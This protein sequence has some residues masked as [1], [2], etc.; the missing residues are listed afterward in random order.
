MKRSM[1]TAVAVS[2]LLGALWVPGALGQA[3]YGSILGTVTDPSG[4]AVNG[5]KVSATSQS[6][7]VSVQA[8]SNESGN[9]DITH[10]IPDVYTVRVEA[11][12]FKVLE[13][14]DVQ[15]SADAGAR[16][17]GQFQLGG[18]S[19][20]VEVTSE[21]PQLKTDREDVSV[22]FS[23]KQLEEL[24]IFNRNF[25]S[26]ELLTPG[27][28]V[29]TGWSHAATE[30]PQGSKQIFVNGQHFSGTG[31][32][33][34]GTD[35]QDAILGIIIVNPSLDSV[36][37]TKITTQNYDAEFGKALG[38]IMTAQTKSG[39]NQ[40][41]GSGYFYDLD[42][43]SAA[44]N[45]FTGTPAPNNWKQFG[46]AVGGHIIK[47]KLFYFG[48]LEIT[49]R[50]EGVSLVAT[51]PTANVRNTCLSATSANCDL[52][53]YLTAN[54]GG[55]A[56][57][58]YNPYQA[59]GTRT[60]YAGNIIPQAAL[61]AVDANFT[62]GLTTSEAILAL[63]P[64]PNATGI[65]NGTVDNYTASGSGNFNDYQYVAR[66]DY[67][68]TQKLQTFGRFS[69]AHFKLSGP[70]VF[71]TAIGGPGLGPLGLAG[72]SVIEN[73]SLATGFNYTLSTSLLTDFR[74]GFFRYNPHST[75]FDGTVAAAT[76]LGIPGL[77]TSD[78]STGG[79]PA[80]IFDQ[81]IGVN[82]S[83]NN[84]IGEGLGI[85]RCNCPLLEREQGI[86][87]VNNWTKMLGNHQF[88][89]GADLR[90]ANNL[91]IPSDNNRTGVLN[92]NHAGTSDNNTG[93]L[94]IATFL[95][96]EVT[97][98]NRYVGSATEQQSHELQNRYFF[99]GQDTWRV[100][101]KL[102]FNYGLRWEF[103]TP[104]H[105]SGQGDGGFAILPEGVIRVAGYGGIGLNGNTR[106]NFNQF[107]PRLGIAYEVSPKTVIRMGYGRSYDI[108]VFGSLFG[109]T[110]TQ[111]LP[112]LANQ[113]LNSPTNDSKTPA[114]NFTGQCLPSPWNPL[115][116]GATPNV[117]PTIP[118]DGILPFFGPCPA[119][120]VSPCEGTVS[121]RSRPDHLIAPTID[122]WNATIQHQLTNKT[123][124]EISYVGNRGMHVFKG[125]SNTYNANQPTVVGFLPPNAGTGLSF[126][127]RAPYTSAFS[128]VYTDSVVGTQTV[129]CCSGTS[130]NYNGNDGI[131]SYKALEIKVDHRTSVGWTF[132]GFWTYAKA[133]DNDGSYQPDL[134]QGT[135]RQDFNRD[136]VIVLT[137]LYELPIGRGKHFM[138]N[139]SRGVD[140]LVGG[141]QWN[142]TMTIASGLPWS[143]GYNNCGF[144]RDTG[145]CRP[146][147]NGTFAM[148]SSSF[149]SQ[150]RS[151]TYFTPVSQQLC[152]SPYSGTS[153]PDCP[154]FVTQSGPFS[155]PGIAQF[156]NIRRNQF[157]GP[158][159]LMSDMSLFKNFS[160]TEG[161]K[162]QF[163]AEFFNIFNHPVYALPGNTCIDCSGAGVINSLQ[164]D[165]QM[166]QMQLGFRV[167]F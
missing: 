78:T 63:L 81:T 86:Q 5:A 101:R 138:G 162:A 50:N 97:S 147:L 35:N 51:V 62:S 163:Q 67:S 117:F 130:F 154:N 41:H 9:Y 22:E 89:F 21:A 2:F 80:L 75:K 65:D 156:G 121:P 8:T 10:L 93:G 19:E 54:L 57:Q 106:D 84:G 105:V 88:K 111:N 157:T 126:N 66:G 44:V 129:V 36:T 39:S 108:G 103:Y 48:N 83:G 40:I 3:V 56:G 43:V 79:L 110:V 155:D 33:L 60:A 146:S 46:G 58:V 6:K 49:R 1:W 102:T 96:G 153:G 73:Y 12:G 18:S 124:L 164:G 85:G 37:E 139:I 158:G 140:Y 115:L 23:G 134:R 26:L 34:D 136:N 166:R 104:E 107:A 149:N 72:Q 128:T 131:N 92:F 59:Q 165:L 143:P 137:S 74:F 160:I 77:N 133:Y 141:W 70:P 17:D 123:S 7:N 76:A 151:V 113:I 42:P 135:G 127:A 13:F 52:S 114:F 28:Q 27:T 132:N 30:N 24:P 68:A 4:A 120:S 69:H 94:D 61:Q 99:Y 148:G 53:E 116:C 98:F 11:Q 47:D 38:G 45:P 25:Q 142:A 95:F 118:S 109:H 55:G 119:G 64:A 32:E 161:I 150:K 112:V 82:S 91:R 87:F 100:T 159:E 144:D 16:V 20:T 145:P 152:D 14:K 71:G 125:D 167:T 122:A 90:H 15:V 29:I 31:Y